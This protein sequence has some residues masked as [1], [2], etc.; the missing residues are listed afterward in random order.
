M[1]T[2]RNLTLTHKKDL[3]VLIE[4]LSFTVNPGERIAVSHDRLFIGNVCT[5][6]ARLAENGF[7]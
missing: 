2:I 1:L 4:N 7:I 3:S 6:E 5:R